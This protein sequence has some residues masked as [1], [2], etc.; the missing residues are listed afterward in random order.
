M[1]ILAMAELYI[2]EAIHAAGY[3]PE[4]STTHWSKYLYRVLYS[5]LS[6]MTTDQALIESAILDAISKDL[7][8][9]KVLS[10]CSQVPSRFDPSRAA[11]DSYLHMRASTWRRDTREY[12]T[13]HWRDGVAGND[14]P[15]AIDDM[16][17][18]AVPAESKVINDAIDIEAF[19]A[20][21]M[22]FDPQ[23]LASFNALLECKP[24]AQAAKVL[25]ISDK[26][27][28]KRRERI[29]ILHD[30]FAAGWPP[31]KLSRLKVA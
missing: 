27:V 13:A 4:S 12:V 6:R 31:P 8:I 2:R 28:A 22:R 5:P 30:H 10:P 16:P 14:M 21:L 25:C 18:V 26:G 17:P 24:D 15:V 3:L 19:R 11:I 7:Y 29:R 1:R 20:Y 23:S 9:R